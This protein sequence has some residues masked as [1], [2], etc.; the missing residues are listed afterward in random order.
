MTWLLR[1]LDRAVWWGLAAVTA[2]MS[3][4]ILVQV[5][6]RLLFGTAIVWA[7]EFAVFLFAWMIFLGAAVAQGSDAHLSIDTLRSYVGPRLGRAMDAF[8][9]ALVAG[10]SLVAIWQGIALTLRT[11]RLL[12]PAM[13]ISRAY[14]YLSVPVGFAI[15]LLYMAG[16]IR[17]RLTR[18]T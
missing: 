3:L 9:L 5:L 12:Y 7:E 4:A 10:C 16:D 17:R 18:G 11:T 15:G 8:R 2:A 1:A 13:E 14:L 6:C